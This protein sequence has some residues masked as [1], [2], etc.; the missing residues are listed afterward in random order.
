MQLLQ[1]GLSQCD[2]RAIIPVG[3]SRVDRL[4]K[5]RELGPE[6]WHTRRSQAAPWHAFS[7]EDIEAFKLHCATWILEDGFPCAH[8]R[9]RQYFTEPNLTWVVVHAH[10]VDDI[11][12]NEPTARTL[13]YT[14]GLRSMC[15]SITQEFGSQELQKA[16]DIR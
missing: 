5:I 2:I 16:F 4:R 9:P 14:L 8:R 3:G 15:T 6:T 1:Q 12:R 11:T 7:D 13:S 10:Y